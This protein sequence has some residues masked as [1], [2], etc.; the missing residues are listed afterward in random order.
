[1]STRG[2]HWWL[3]ISRNKNS[4][5]VYTVLNGNTVA[6]KDG[7][8]WMHGN[9]CKAGPLK[10][11]RN[12]C[13]YAVCFGLGMTLSCVSPPGLTLFLSAL[14]MVALGISLLRH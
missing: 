2:R 4:N 6:G 11:P 12:R 10:D 9:Y 7:D 8:D 14:I 1:M 5:S 3:S 13:M